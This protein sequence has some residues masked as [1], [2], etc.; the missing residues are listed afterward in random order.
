MENNKQNI[1]VTWA[2]WHFY[3]MPRFLLEVWKNYILFALN[4]FSLPDL[5]KSLFAPWRKYK[6][7]YP[8]GFAVGEFLSTFISNSF[9]RILGAMMRIVLIVAGI[10]FLVFVAV[11]GL[12]IFLAWIL[13]PFIIIG[14]FLFAINY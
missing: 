12:I 6:W 9:S 14:G 3:E 7:N 4:Y 10:L 1:F 5:L 8:K 11:S 2:L 13:V